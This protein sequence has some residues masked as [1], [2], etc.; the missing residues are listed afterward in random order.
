MILLNVSFGI[1]AFLPQG[2]VFMIA[3]ILIECLGISYFLT[4]KWFNKK[5]YKTTMLSNLISGIIGIIGSMILNG[6]WWLV[7]WF[8]WVSNNEVSGA[9][10]LNLLVMFYA[11]AFLLT[12]L[13]EGLVNYLLLKRYYKK[14]QVLKTTFIVNIISYTIGSLA[15]YSYSF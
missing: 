12:L 2:W 6:G 7:V 15:M 11:I 14:S 13:I 5:I 8:P 10:G 1:Y 4:Y 9:E 3:I